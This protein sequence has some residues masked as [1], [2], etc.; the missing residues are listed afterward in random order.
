M[1]FELYLDNV[2]KWQF[3]FSEPEEV[4]V[5]GDFAENYMYVIQDEI[6]GYHWNKR[7]RTLHPIVIYYRTHDGEELVQSLCFVSD[8]LDHDVIMVYNIVKDAINHVK[9][10]LP[11][12]IKFILWWL[13]STIQKL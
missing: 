3:F 13:C 2:N 12:K 11:M 4:I 7:Q 9:T 6:Q 1:S 5:L 10:K 8:D